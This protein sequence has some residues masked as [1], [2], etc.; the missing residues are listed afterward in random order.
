MER[1][2]GCECRKA[3]MGAPPHIRRTDTRLLCPSHRRNTMS[4]LLT[5]STKF[6]D[7]TIGEQLAFLV[8]LCI[9]CAT[10]GFAFPTLLSD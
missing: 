2:I 9:F 5:P 7:M 6:K 4:E 10:F 3:T 1:G 8:K